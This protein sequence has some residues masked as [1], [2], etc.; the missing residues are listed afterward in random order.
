MADQTSVGVVRNGVEDELTWLDAWQL[1]SPSGPSAKLR[2]RKMATGSL[3]EVDRD[4]AEPLLPTRDG[5]LQTA[6]GGELTWSGGQLKA[7]G[8]LVERV[9]ST[10]V[11]VCDRSR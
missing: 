5:R 6:T 1:E 2:V 3:R 8:C 7:A 10:M 9:T 4:G 11:A